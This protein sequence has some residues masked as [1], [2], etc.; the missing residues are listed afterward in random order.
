MTGFNFQFSVEVKSITP[1]V[2]S[3][4]FEGLPCRYVEEE[5]EKKKEPG[6]SLSITAA[7]GTTRS[8]NLQ[9]MKYNIWNE[10]G[11]ICASHIHSVWSE[12][13]RRSRQTRVS[14]PFL[15]TAD[16]HMPV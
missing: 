10:A 3:D 2:R 4:S 11:I 13:T 12:E 6:G 15:L 9:Q 8:A 16:Q 5:E 1:L 7:W 14:F